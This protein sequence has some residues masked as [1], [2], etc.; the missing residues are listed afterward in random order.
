VSRAPLAA[1]ALAAAAALPA[2]ADDAAAWAGVW[3]GPELTLELA[4]APDGLGGWLRLG[5]PLD[6]ERQPYRVHPVRAALV[7]GSLRG[8]AG[9]LRWERA[10]RAELDGGRL[11]VRL[12]EGPPVALVREPEETTGRSPLLARVLGPARAAGA[13]EALARDVWFAAPGAD[14]LWRVVVEPTAEGLAVRTTVIGAGGRTATESAAFG[15]DGRLVALRDQ[16][17]DVDDP[18][19]HQRHRLTVAPDGAVRLRDEVAERAQ[20]WRWDDLALPR[21]LAWLVLPAL[22]EPAPDEAVFRCVEGHLCQPRLYRLAR[23]GPDRWRLAG[24]PDLAPDLAVTRLGGR[25]A[26]PLEVRVADA[27]DGRRVTAIERG[28]EPVLVAVSAEEAARRLAA[29]PP[30]AE[31]RRGRH[32]A[33][34]LAVLR[35]LIGAVG[36]Y[37]GE[38][39]E[40]PADLDALEAA[41]FWDPGRAASVFWLKGYELALARSPDGAR[42]MAVAAPTEPGVSG[43]RWFAVADGPPIRWSDAPIE[44]GP[45][46]SLEGTRPLGE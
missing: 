29:L 21:G 14:V 30:P 20:G 5:G 28:A 15:W 6:P 32:E 34:A 10:L 16:E 45:E 35:S 12:G 41:G 37:R 36:A 1:L 4:P 42:W 19:E 24:Q 2:A 25:P 22:G 27:P 13:F 7:D 26:E 23:V 46:C 40:C 18:G 31:V 3:V 39:G 11:R 43:A 38:R 17:G 44:A 9:A 33:R 8:S